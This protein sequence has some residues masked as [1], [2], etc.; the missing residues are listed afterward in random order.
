MASRILNENYLQLDTLANSFVSSEQAA[1]PVLNAYNAQRRSKVWRSNG[2]WEITSSNNTF[3]FKETGLGATLTATLPVSNY[4]STTSMLAALKTAMELV[5]ADTFTCEV[6][7]TT[8]K[9]KITSSGSAF[10]IVAGGT[11]NAVLGYTTLPKTGALNYRADELRIHSFEFIKWDFGISTNPGAFVLIGKRNSPI[12]ISPS[13]II[14]LQGNSTDVWTAPEY[15]KTITYDDEIM[16]EFSEEN[17]LH[18]QALRYWRLYIDDKSN[19]NGFVEIGA[20]FLG[21]YFEPTRGAIQFPFNGSYIDRSNV[22]FSEGGQ[23][24]S[25]IRQKSE[26]FDVTWDALTTLEK[27]QIDLIF[28]EYGVSKPLFIAFDPMLAFSSRTNYYTRF[29]K[30]DGAPR[31]TL[32]DPNFWSVSMSFREEL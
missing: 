2:Y 23:T 17:E 10:Q 19:P 32:S 29:V 24:F 11:L 31:Y 14:K 30:F 8:K 12:S 3:T 15:E 28:D 13:A 16:A 18:T 7:S 22:A 9:I 20:L 26:S 25:D 6:D 1:F 21:K 4:T 27:E 5:S